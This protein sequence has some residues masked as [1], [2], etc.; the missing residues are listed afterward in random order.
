[1]SIHTGFY[2]FRDS[3]SVSPSV[4]SIPCRVFFHASSYPAAGYSCDIMYLQF[5]NRSTYSI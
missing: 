2:H 1:M 4:R 5:L 3:A